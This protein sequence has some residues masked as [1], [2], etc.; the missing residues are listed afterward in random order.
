MHFQKR[1]E[2]MT[3]KF[4]LLKNVVNA[5]ILCLCIST[6]SFSTMYTGIVKD[7]KSGNPVKGVRVSLGYTNCVTTTDERGNFTLS[8]EVSVK[9]Q[10]S[11]F[12]S[13]KVDILCNRGNAFLNFSSSP[14]AKTVRLFSLNGKCIYQR[15]ISPDNPIVKMQPLSKGI[16]VIRIESAFNTATS[17]RINTVTNG[18]T[19]VT[20]ASMAR[21]GGRK[22]SSISTEPLL[23]KHDSYYP[24]SISA[25]GAGSAIAVSLKPDP[26]GHVFDETRVYTYN[27]TISTADSLK[28]EKE[29]LL[30]NYVP[31]QFIFNDSSIGQIGI[32]YKGSS[33]SLPN[34]FDDNGTR[35]DIPVCKKISLKLKFDKYSNSQRFFSMKRLNLHSMSA[36][37][38]KMHD[39]LS[40]GLFRE[41]GIISPRAA[42]VKVYINSVFQGLFL[43][44][45]DPDSRFADARWPEDPDGNMYKEKWP[46]SDKEDYYKEGLVTN[47][48]PED[49]ADVSKMISFYKSINE[50]SASDFIDK[51]SRFINFDY[52]LRYIA[53]DRAIHNAD[54][55][56]TWYVTTGWKGNHN[57]FFYEETIPDGKVWQIPWDMDNTFFRRDPIVDDMGSPEWNVTPLSCEPIEVWG[58][59]QAMPAHCDKLTGMTADLL[60]DKYVKICEPMLATYFSVPH[61]TSK[62]DCYKEIID[63]IVSKDPYMD[64]NT[65][66]SAV[67]ALRKDLSILNS[68]YDDYI[69]K[70]TPTFDTSGFTQPFSGNGFLVT[71]KVNNFEFTPELTQPAWA[72]S[73]ASINTIHSITHNIIQPLCG[74][75]DVKLTYSIKS[76][77]EKGQYLEWVAGVLS[78]EK[79]TNISNIKAIQINLKGES[80]RTIEISIMTPLYEK[81][82]IPNRYGWIEGISNKD[83]IRI[84]KR[85]EISYPF[86]D[87]SNSPNILDSALTHATG[88]AFIPYPK[89]DDFGKLVSE[90]DSGFVQIDNIR[91]IY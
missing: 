80:K 19:Q 88:I 25:P 89:F 58:G 28:M 82:N 49:S 5:G 52:F 45:E 90:P 32:R 55:M 40:Y 44:V 1:S 15:T 23:F 85:S 24:Q 56:M 9:N 62:L 36:D 75:G 10:K 61:L 74:K 67:K 71:D 70:R 39:I 86:W 20:I 16:Y 83:S 27:F 73:V 65:W 59:S 84:F 38:T 48:K 13:E 6:I 31:A 69:H 91:F 46:I 42:F 17:F 43:A 41:M 77:P 63:T 22:A 66:Q 18:K 81:Y 79:E 4:S 53:V 47:E 8:D 7:S 14:S 72:T 26:R 2:G 11:I 87:T 50:A 68:S 76:V 34:C 78:F 64:Y 54:G 37:D 57:Y 3:V 12:S 21:T 60:W 30:E 33:Y 35:T 29:A 51:V